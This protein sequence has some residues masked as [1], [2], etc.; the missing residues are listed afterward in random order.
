MLLDSHGPDVE[1]PLLYTNRPSSSTSDPA[2]RH[3]CILGEISDLHL[4]CSV[5]ASWRWQGGDSVSSECSG[6]FRLQ[7]GHPLPSTRGGLQRL[8]ELWQ[9]SGKQRVPPTGWRKPSL[10]FQVMAALAFVLVPNMMAILVPLSGW[11]CILGKKSYEGGGE[12]RIPF[13]SS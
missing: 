2:R 9:P 4:P 7:G 5:L 10:G 8:S 11:L 6:S 13:S 1:H 12:K 3:T